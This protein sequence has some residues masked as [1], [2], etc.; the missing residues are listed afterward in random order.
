MLSQSDSSCS[1]ILFGGFGS[2]LVFF[3][4]WLETETLSELVHSILVPS[5][6]LP[7][8]CLLY[9]VII[10]VNGLPFLPFTFVQDLL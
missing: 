2:I 9:V 5:E 3:Y 4:T 7:L 10:K 6:F 8:N 1:Y